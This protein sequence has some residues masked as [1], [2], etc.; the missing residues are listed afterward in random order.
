[1]SKRAKFQKTAVLDSRIIRHLET[2]FQ[3][4][5]AAET[6]SDF[7]AAEKIYREIVGSFER[8]HLN[9]ATPN[10]ALGFVL[11]G[12]RKFEECEKV[13]KRSAQLNPNLLEAHAN[14]TV[15]YRVT[16]RFEEAILS[17][18]R[19]L[20]V[21]PKHLQTLLT[22]GDVQREIRLYRS[23]VQNYLLALALDNEN[24]HARRGLAA[25]YVFLGDT[26]V[27]IP[28]YR[29]VLEAEPASWPMM[30]SMF[31]ALQYEPTISNEEVLHEHL[32]YGRKVRE[33]LPSPQASFPN[34]RTPDRRL[35][36]GY[37]SNDFKYHVVMRFVEHVFACHDHEKFEI[38]FIATNHKQDK[39]TARIRHH[40][41]RWIDIHEMSDEQAVQVV[42][43]EQLDILVD[44]TGHS[45]DNRLTAVAR[46][47]APVQVL[48]CGYSGTSGVDTMDY[49]IVDNIL[50]PT[51]EKAYFTEEPLRMPHSFVAFHSPSEYEIVSPPFERNGFVTFGCMN[52]PSKINKYVVTWWAQI[53][54][55]VP[56]SKLLMRY[57][58]FVEPLVRER[59]A[60][61]FRECGID[62]DRY[63]MREGEQEFITGYNGIDIA[64]DTFP[65]N[66]TTTTCEALWMGVPVVAI[67]GDRFVSRVGA[68]LL[69]CAG[70]TELI[71]ESP[72]GYI[73]IAVRLAGD[74]DKLAELRS[75]LR[76]HLLTTPLFDSHGFAR[77]LEAAYVK[78]FSLWC[79]Q[80]GDNLLALADATGNKLPQANNFHF[81]SEVFQ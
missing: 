16:E 9:A 37:I 4:G 10:A 27:A 59:I 54:K 79:E 36:I 56:N 6:A 3:E 73:D 62:S 44:L 38:C 8:N 28:M 35:R 20:K 77:D 58:F 1:M 61:I 26:S 70:M 7:T 46:R 69:S 31:F 72:E 5:K 76:P 17:G 60:R 64:L 12:Q 24:M 47:L 21:D 74:L 48:W 78:I 43:D 40:A 34:P 67:R 15:L 42:R 53:L 33:E 75:S 23:S 14:L 19:A 30:S 81:S 65:Y 80:Q 2:R 39:D 22:M 32:E 45:G 66:G 68:S 29:K 18:R 55:A 71:A 11:L 50:A 13:L 41:D 63:E 57:A 52:N 51:G 49:V 25:N